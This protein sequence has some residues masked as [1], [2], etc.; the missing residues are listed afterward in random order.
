MRMNVL[1]LTLTFS[2]KK[3]EKTVERHLHE[4]HMR[5]VRDELLDKLARNYNN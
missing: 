3:R 5:K 4:Q 2:I 1:S